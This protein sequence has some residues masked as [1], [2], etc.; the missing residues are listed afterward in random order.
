[1]SLSFSNSLQIVIRIRKGISGLSTGT[2]QHAPRTCRTL[3]YPVVIQ[4]CWSTGIIF[5]NNHPINEMASVSISWETRVKEIVQ[6]TSSRGPTHIVWMAQNRILVLCQLTGFV[7][8]F[9]ATAAAAAAPNPNELIRV[10]IIC[11]RVLSW[12]EKKNPDNGSVK[13]LK[14]LNKTKSKQVTKNCDSR[15]MRLS[16]TPVTV[17]HTHRPRK[18][19]REFLVLKNHI[20]IRLCR[21]VQRWSRIDPT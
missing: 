11:C 20:M 10:L 5:R 17:T 4:N 3:F 12:K 2:T 6:I 19:K 1:M 8:R 7:S 9:M 16:F 14:N 13:D 21:I 15:P 18:R